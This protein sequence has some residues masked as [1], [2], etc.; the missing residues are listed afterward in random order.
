MAK[1]L[2]KGL[3]DLLANI[4]D[5]SVPGAVSVSNEEAG[6]VYEIDIESV[7][8]NPKQPRKYFGEGQLEELANSIRVQGIIT[9]LIL[10]KSGDK[11][12]IVAGERRYRAAQS[13]GLKT[14][15]AIVKSLSEREIREVSLIENLQREDLNPIEEAEAMSEL[16]AMYS[17]TQEALA[18][19]IGKARPSVANAMRLLQLDDEVKDLV[20]R[21]RLSA[22]HARALVALK[23]GS[24]QVEFAY[25]AC[26]GQMTVRELEKKVQYTLH[27][28]LKPQRRSDAASRERMSLEMRE[29]VDDM[30]RIFLTKV[31]LVGND[32][33]GRIYI[34]YF[35][36]DDLQRIYELMEKLK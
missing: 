5:V 22:G 19:R 13:V 33:K 2:S 24:E 21:G 16:A 8:P 34:D 29:L 1:R 26:D 17:L 3:T 6:S 9:P 15:P 7:I 14:V 35:S 23:D 25:R 11:Y 27:P 10:V 36:A 31:K 20:R 30:K 12:M 28:E 18:V 4:E 32:K